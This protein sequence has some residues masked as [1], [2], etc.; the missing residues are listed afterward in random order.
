MYRSFASP[1]DRAVLQC[2]EHLD[3]RN[4]LD[5]CQHEE[6]KIFPVRLTLASD[7]EEDQTT[8]FT[9]VGRYQVLDEVNIRG[10]PALADTGNQPFPNTFSSAV[11]WR[12][13]GGAYLAD[14]RMIGRSTPDH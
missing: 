13:V 9:D 14:H 7:R 3:S 1:P 5:R 2:D 6:E 10:V 8:R 4:R 12:G 11:K